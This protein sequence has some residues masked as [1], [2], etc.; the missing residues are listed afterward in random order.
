MHQHHSKTI[1]PARRRIT[2]MAAVAGA[3]GLGIGAFAGVANAAPPPNSTLNGTIVIQSA[4]SLEPSTG[5]LGTITAVPGVPTAFPA[6]DF[7][8]QSTDSSGF[9]LSSYV[10]APFGSIPNGDLSTDQWTDTTNVLGPAQSYVV[11]DPAF[12]ATGPGGSVNLYT[13]PWVTGNTGDGTPT[14]TT[15]WGGASPISLPAPNIGSDQFTSVVHVSIAN[16]TPGTAT[17]GVTGSV[18]YLLT[19]A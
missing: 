16:G 13:S 10:S 17:A 11:A 5:S 18:S 1:S 6:F 9:T 8:V 15:T 7:V 19:G 2:R 14:S 3:A 12:G 4:L